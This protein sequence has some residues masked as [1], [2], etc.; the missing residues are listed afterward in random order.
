MT[1][2]EII[3][4]ILFVLSMAGAFMA[5]QPWWYPKDDGVLKTVFEYGTNM[6]ICASMFIVGMILLY[7]WG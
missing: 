5:M 7:I 2:I 6:W 4:V 3:A 1:G